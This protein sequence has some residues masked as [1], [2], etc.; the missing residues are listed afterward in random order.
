MMGIGF[1]ELMVILVIIMIIFGAGKLPE[2]GSAFGN[3][4]KNFKKSFAYKLDGRCKTPIFSDNNRYWA[5]HM[6]E[7]VEQIPTS[8]PSKTTFYFKNGNEEKHAAT[9]F[10]AKLT[11]DI[12]NQAVELIDFFTKSNINRMVTH[13]FLQ[14]NL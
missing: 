6:D 14:N 7:M 12:E 8:Q 9:R 10:T 4:I 3:S 5:T 13:F 1:P 11:K 2:I